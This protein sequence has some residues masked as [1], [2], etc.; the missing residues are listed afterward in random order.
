M[1]G[2]SL[3]SHLPGNT[4]YDHAS[5]GSAHTGGQ[6]SALTVFQLPLRARSFLL[7]LQPLIFSSKLHKISTWNNFCIITP[8]HLTSASR[9]ATF[10][11]S[12]LI[13]RSLSWITMREFWS[14]RRA[15]RQSNTEW[16]PHKYAARNPVFAFSVATCGPHL[17]N[18]VS[19]FPLLALQHVVQMVDLLFQNSHLLLQ[20]L[21]SESPRIDLEHRYLF[22]H[23]GMH[24]SSLTSS[25]LLALPPSSCAACRVPPRGCGWSPA[26][27]RSPAPS[28]PAASA[29]LVRADL[30][31]RCLLPLSSTCPPAHSGAPSVCSLQPVRGG[32]GEVGALLPVSVVPP[33]F[34]PSRW[35]CYLQSLF[36]LLVL[37]FG[38]LEL[39]V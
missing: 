30:S 36:L 4:P 39:C 23:P 32:H 17:F 31:S 16:I 20:L 37:L 6:R 13:T 35:S 25:L 19:D 12:S 22:L 10:S 18:H 3:T 27:R 14:C 28:L 21:R 33:S 38:L 24:G 7:P 1:K 26:G 11:S 15:N 2:R 9:K 34:P 29:A 8:K 5:L